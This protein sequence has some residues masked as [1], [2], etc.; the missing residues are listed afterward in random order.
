M[1]KE[2]TEI[3]DLSRKDC[4]A[5]CKKCNITIE[6][7]VQPCKYA[8]FYLLSFHNFIFYLII[9]IYTS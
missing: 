8:Y 1:W 2:F 7:K 9:N 4:K 6:G 3:T 5:K